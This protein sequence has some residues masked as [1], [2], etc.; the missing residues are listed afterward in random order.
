MANYGSNV[1][2]R[3]STE[4]RTDPYALITRI[5]SRFSKSF[6][7]PRRFVATRG[8]AECSATIQIVQTI[9][10]KRLETLGGAGSK[11]IRN[12]EKY[13]TFVKRAYVRK[14]TGH[15]VQC[16]P[17][18]SPQTV[19]GNP[20]SL[21]YVFTTHVSGVGVP[22]GRIKYPLTSR[23]KTAHYTN[24]RTNAIWSHLDDVESRGN[25]RFIRSEPPRRN[26]LASPQRYR[27]TR[28]N[29]TCPHRTRVAVI[30]IFICL[31]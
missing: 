16:E 23:S 29:L 26:A 28:I 10:R 4:F 21:L 8:F 22:T 14:C 5:Q 31:L 30:W 1:P 19:Y 7:L 27:G 11:E 9:R 15:V 20:S 13:L 12:E 18:K 24:P 3:G 17:S 6:L 25:D 2:H